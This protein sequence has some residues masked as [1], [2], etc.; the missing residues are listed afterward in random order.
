MTHERQTAIRSRFA[1]TVAGYEG[2]PRHARDAHR[3]GETA[4]RSR[5]K[6]PIFGHTTCTSEATDKATWHRRYRAIERV[7]RRAEGEDYTAHSHRE[8]SNAATFAKDGNTIGL[9]LSALRTCGNRKDA[10]ENAQYPHGS[11]ADQA[12]I[13]TVIPELVVA[14]LQLGAATGDAPRIIRGS[15]SL[16][17]YSPKLVPGSR[18]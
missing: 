10:P 5:K 13:S 1:Q 4:S 11:P 14:T 2:Q 3:Q 9:P 7:R 6:T 8:N 12:P 16:G 18:H 17:G 15:S